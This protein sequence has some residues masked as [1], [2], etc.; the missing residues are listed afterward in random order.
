MKLGKTAAI[1]HHDPLVCSQ[2]GEEEA[3]VF[4]Q[5]GANKEVGAVGVGLCEGG[6]AAPFADF[7]VVAVG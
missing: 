1:F 6:F 2:F 4:G 5:I 7:Y 3:F